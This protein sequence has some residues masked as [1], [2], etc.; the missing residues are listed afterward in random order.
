MLLQKK[1]NRYAPLAVGHTGYKNLYFG[2][3][4]G[5][6]GGLCIGGEVG[7]NL[8]GDRIAGCSDLAALL[9]GDG[10]ISLCVFAACGNAC[11]KGRE[12]A[13]CNFNFGG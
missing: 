11:G 13:V 9:S 8:N 10:N 4:S 7:G 2:G 5:W 1:E 6:L 12:R 3:R